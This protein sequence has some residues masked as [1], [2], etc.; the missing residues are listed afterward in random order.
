MSFSIFYK[1]L[2]TKQKINFWT[3]TFLSIIIVFFEL[4]SIGLVIPLISIILDPQI[5]LDRLLKFDITIF[6]NIENTLI[7]ENFIF[8]FLIFF[9]LLY[10]FK[11]LLFF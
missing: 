7:N 2:N 1:L 11:N 4:L 5:I 3:L 10:A 8:Y 6:N 9:V